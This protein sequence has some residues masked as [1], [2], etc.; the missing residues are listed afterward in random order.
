MR[1]RAYYFGFNPTGVEAIDRILSAVACAGKAYHNTS[2]W[3]EDIEP[4]EDFLRGRT[5]AEWIQYAADDAAALL[6][7]ALRES[8]KLQSHYAT[9]LNMHDGG[10]R[11]TFTVESWMARLAALKP[12]EPTR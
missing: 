4:Y 12:Q 8:V 2:E 7:E 6:L 11:M 5:C 1:L 9:L 10:E 3:Q